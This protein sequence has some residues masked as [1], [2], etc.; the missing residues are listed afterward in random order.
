[1]LRSLVLY[2][3]IALCIA[4]VPAQ[5]MPGAVEW[6]C[7]ANNPAELQRHLD[8]H[9]GALEEALQAKAELDAHTQ[10]LNG[11]RGGAAYTISVVFH[12]IHNNGPENISDAQIQDAVRIL[13]EDFNKENPDWV[14][15]RPE[16]LDIVGDVGITFALARKDPDGNCTNGITRTESIQ[17]YDGDFDM[18]QLIQWPRD[19]YLN[20]WAAASANGA[21]GYT[22]YPQWLNNW[23]EADGIVV[24]ANYVGSIGTS[25]ASHSR[26]LSHEVGHWLNLKHCWGDS[27]EP[28]LDS[29]CNMDD[30]VED[31]PLTKGWTSCW[32]GA[33][34]C[35]SEL[36]NVENYMEYSYC[37]KMF[38]NRQADRMIAA[39]TSPIAQRNQLWQPSTLLLTG[40]AEEP[41][42]CEA[43]FIHGGTEICAGGTVEFNDV[44][45]NA[46]SE[47]NWS[48][49]GGSPSTSSEPNPII[50]YN[51]PGVYPVSLSVSDGVTSQ[52]VVSEAL[53]TVLPSV[54]A[55]IPFTESFE[56]TTEMGTTEWMIRNPDDDQTWELTE[57]SAYTG[58][59]SVRI[60][61]DSWSDGNVDDLYSGTYD[62]SEA[63]SISITFRY[64]F[65]RRLSGNDDRLK[66]YVSKDCGATWSLRKQLRGGTDLPTAPNTGGTFVPNGGDQWGFASINN[67]SANYHAS[68]FRIRFEF[69]S[70]GGNALYLDD[71]NINGLPVGLAE[72]GEG[73][74][75]LVVV[76]NPVSD[77][78]V[79]Q[80][81]LDRPGDAILELMDPTGRVVEQLFRSNLA[82]G[83]N[84]VGIAADRFASGIYLLRLRTGDRFRVTP[85][86][87]E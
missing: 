26:V 84:R 86:A 62:M 6:N 52:E 58:V 66:C 11:Q 21:A 14:N 49:P 73:I 32:L 53:I 56:T 19:R 25:S 80:F 87:I 68:D 76:P 70:D 8:A 46:V 59:R 2:S 63:E 33:S 72:P 15:V 54:G 10:A 36:D 69:I 37:D 34:S 65:A 82:S 22:Y 51:V 85:L 9:P 1:M 44:S 64:A 79:V 7:L 29:N 4:S 67:I 23:P 55:G 13:N 48:F 40:V 50:Q 31:T 35:G 5:N 38:T 61:N 45:Y 57:V 16:F 42:L 71:I 77:L 75:D 60:L 39:L 18:T 43:G 17:T 83:T 78:A 24:L 28:G 12:V 30:E 20:I 74:V 27:N 41:Q 81:S 3:S 47:R